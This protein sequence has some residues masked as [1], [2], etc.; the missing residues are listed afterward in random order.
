MKMSDDSRDAGR[1]EDTRT[2]C[3]GYIAMAW[4]PSP[5][6][7]R[8]QNPWH[9]FKTSEPPSPGRK[10]WHFQIWSMTLS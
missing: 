1:D 8:L 10:Q 9:P 7:S 3:A 5:V 6:K 4:Q 2:G